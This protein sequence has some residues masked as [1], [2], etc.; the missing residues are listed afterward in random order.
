MKYNVTLPPLPEFD[1]LAW[2][3]QEQPAVIL[4]LETSRKVSS[5]QTS[6]VKNCRAALPE[7]VYYHVRNG[8]YRVFALVNYDHC[9]GIMTFYG[10]SW[11]SRPKEMS[12]TVPNGAGAKSL[13]Y[14]PNEKAVLILQD[15]YLYKVD[16]YDAKVKKTIPLA[17]RAVFAGQNI[18]IVEDE[19]IKEYS[20]KGSYIKTISPS[21]PWAGTI[22]SGAVNYM[23]GTIFVCN[24]AG[25]L[26]IINK[27]DGGK[28]A[29]GF[30]NDGRFKGFMIVG[31]NG[32]LLIVAS[33]EA[34]KIYWLDMNFK[35]VASIDYSTT[36]PGNALLTFDGRDLLALKKTDGTLYTFNIQDNW[37]YAGVVYTA[38]KKPAGSL[39]PKFLDTDNIYI[40]YCEYDWD[41]DKVKSVIGCLDANR[42]ATGLMFDG[43]LMM[44]QTCNGRSLMGDGPAAGLPEWKCYLDTLM[45]AGGRYELAALA[46]GEIQAEARLP[47]FK[48]KVFVGIPYPM[49][50]LQ[51]YQWFIDECIYRAAV[52]HNV[53]LA[54][55]YY[56]Q[57]FK[58]DLLCKEIKEYINSKGLAYIWSPGYPAKKSVIKSKSL[59]DAI[60]YQTGYPWGYATSAKGKENELSLAIDNIIKFGIYP[61]IESMHDTRWFTFTRD[62]IYTLWDILLNYGVYSTTKLHF[63]GFSQVPESC[64]SVNPF[65]RQLYNLYHEF[66]RGRRT[67]GTAK[68][69]YNQDNDYS[70]TLP[71]EIIADKI[72]IMPRFTRNPPGKKARTLLLKTLNVITEDVTASGS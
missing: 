19:V 5:I 23:E 30:F 6:F 25:R 28:L 27:A 52:Y 9:S 7:A 26:A 14:M 42:K 68:P 71:K 16:R 56:P 11:D 60:F 72:R 62:K 20:P 3:E 48:P 58:P 33:T 50:S 49:D 31:Y 55:F 13:G 64:F 37:E 54:G 32:E 70:L 40:F 45:N 10:K 1:G 51:R 69:L 2:K 39:P 41:K 46:A 44:S 66:L 43:L 57:E 29:E 35:K 38:S 61:N 24:E 67:P 47:N 18:Y 53:V 17:A 65:E 34:E 22:N 15:R 63:T 12:K 8:K 59:F 4:D 21:L 36:I